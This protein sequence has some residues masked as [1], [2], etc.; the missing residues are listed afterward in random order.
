MFVFFQKSIVRKVLFW[1]VL[2]S[3]F[4]LGGVYYLYYSSFECIPFYVFPVVLGVILFFLLIL[5]VKEILYPF[6]LILKNMKALLMGKKYKKIY[7]N[8]LD[9][10]GIMA[11]FFN[12]VTKGFE[13]VSTDIEEEKRMLTEL[14]IASDL[15]KGILPV[16]NPSIAGLDVVAKT[17]SAVEL[18]GDYFDFITRGDNT[19]IYIGDVTGHG[20]PAALVMI[21]VSTLIH[22]LVEFYDNAY[23][24]IVNTN[25]QLKTKIKSTMFM[26][27]LMLRWNSKE[28][29]MSFVGCG[30]E[31]LLVY[32]SATNK[33]EKIPSG[34]IGLGMVA[35]NSKIVKEKSID[36]NVGDVI[37][38]YTDGVTEARNMS[39]EMYDV[40]RLVA[41][42]ERFAPE[43]GADGI[44]NHIAL[45]YSKFVEEHVQDDDVTLLVVKYVGSGK[46]ESASSVETKLDSK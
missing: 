41:A 21:M 3:L 22:T 17:R 7:T 5:I 42:I 40:P 11:H 36:I 8:R 18:G 27:M 38:L 28:Q 1:F 43:Y 33:C 4:V 45:D 34:G 15:Q 12:E 29:K 14:E 20:V 10:I 32:R 25:K 31:Y 16:S 19:Y 35:D 6:M 23:D 24:I 9:E 46:F 2:L 13:K 26:T 44:V 30:H 37:V 39:G